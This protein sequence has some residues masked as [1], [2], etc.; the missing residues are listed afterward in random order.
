[1]VCKFPTQRQRESLEQRGE[2]PILQAPRGITAGLTGLAATGA[3]HAGNI[4]MCQA[5]ELEEVL[6]KPATSDAYRSR[7]LVSLP[8][9]CGHREQLTKAAHLGSHR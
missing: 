9:Q 1:L 8:P 5:S 4:G 3:R 7:M 6:K 2:A